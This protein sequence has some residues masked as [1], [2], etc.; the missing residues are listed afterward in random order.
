MMIMLWTWRSLQS[1][2]LRIL[3]VSV[4]LSCLR[5]CMWDSEDTQFLWNFL[6]GEMYAGH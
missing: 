4:E 6:V 1:E 3:I 2:M 5:S